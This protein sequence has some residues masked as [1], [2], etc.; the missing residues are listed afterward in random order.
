MTGWNE[1]RKEEWTTITVRKKT[2][3]ELKKI[4][5]RNFDVIINDLIKFKR[6]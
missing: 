5:G 3:T 6:G 4:R 2:V 1:K